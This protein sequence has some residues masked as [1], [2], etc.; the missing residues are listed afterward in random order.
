[1]PDIKLGCIER[2]GNPS[3]LIGGNF[4][5]KFFVVSLKNFT[6]M[7]LQIEM[8]FSSSLGDLS[9]FQRVMSTVGIYYTCY[10]LKELVEL[11]LDT[12]LGRSPL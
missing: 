3:E 2:D 4:T 1:M 7:F 8:L 5:L 10:A 12:F 6:M 9:C 11:S